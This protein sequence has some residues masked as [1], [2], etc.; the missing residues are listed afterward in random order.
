MTMPPLHL[1]FS[2]LAAGTLRQTLSRLGRAEPVLCAYDDFSFGPIAGDDSNRAAWVEDVLAIDDWSDVIRDTAP[3]LRAAGSDNLR[4]V[5]WVSHRNARCY[6]G[7]LR[8]LSHRGDAPCD[9]IDV[10]D[11]TRDGIE[12]NAGDRLAL[13]TGALSNEA[14]ARLLG[15][16]RPL[17]QSERR[18]HLALWQRLRSEDAPFRV[19]GPDGVL[20]SAGL[21]HF[22]PLLLSCMTFEW[23]KAARVIGEALADAM[24]TNIAQAGDLVL[25]ACACR[26]AERGAL[27][28]RG[29]LTSM[30][31]CEFRLPASHP[32]DDRMRR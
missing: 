10:T 14:M 16:E 27:E 31:A 29:D 15:T 18:R 12:A 24:D 19:V 6:A 22:D 21:D 17:E 3:M 5:V 30:A 4:P 11:L 28:W 2:P 26:L 13:G 8:W 20:A 32:A 25:Y 7:F 23:R 9:I 1:L